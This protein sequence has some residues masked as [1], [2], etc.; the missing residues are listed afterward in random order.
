MPVKLLFF[1]DISRWLIGANSMSFMANCSYMS[2]KN[3]VGPLTVRIWGNRWVCLSDVSKHFIIIWR[4]ILYQRVKCHYKGHFTSSAQQGK[5]FQNTRTDSV[6]PVVK[7]CSRTFS[8][9]FFCNSYFCDI[10]SYPWSDGYFWS[11]SET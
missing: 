1:G 3:K 10:F 11:I 7:L 6:V 8:H 2:S 4:N 9:I 5:K